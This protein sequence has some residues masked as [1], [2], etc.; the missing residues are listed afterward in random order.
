MISDHHRISPGNAI[1]LPRLASFQCFYQRGV[2][3]TSG[4]KESSVVYN[5]DSDQVWV[6]RS[7]SCCHSVQGSASTG[8]GGNEPPER[9]SDYSR[10]E[11]YDYLVHQSPIRRWL[12]RLL[13]FFFRMCGRDCFTGGSGDEGAIRLISADDDSDPYS[14]ACENALENYAHELDS[15]TQERVMGILTQH[16]KIVVDVSELGEW[17]RRCIESGRY[18]QAA[19]EQ[20]E[21][22]H[23]KLRLK[24][25]DLRTCFENLLR[26]Y[27]RERRDNPER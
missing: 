22:E 26:S 14:E 18:S 4:K 12:L 21:A 9:P 15:L 17:I 13:S 23:L 5:A 16:S 10:Q 7:G 1:F 2:G 8:S 20:L 6:L 25:A 24:E 19:I 11:P 27:C 3:S